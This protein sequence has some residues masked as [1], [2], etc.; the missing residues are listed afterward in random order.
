M[1]KVEHQIKTV[2]R[3]QHQLLQWALKGFPEDQV[4]SEDKRL[5]KAREALSEHKAGLEIKLRAS[6]DAIINVP[7]LESFIERIKG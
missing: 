2:D 4:I 5:N 7:K 3:G 6:Q 1:E